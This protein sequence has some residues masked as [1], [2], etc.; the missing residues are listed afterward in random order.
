MPLKGLAQRETKQYG[1]MK[2][3]ELLLAFQPHLPQP[4]IPK[5]ESIVPLNGPGLC[6]LHPGE[7]CSG[8]IRFGDKEGGLE[9]IRLM[10]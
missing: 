1:V 9:S 7:N 6:V 8:R 10:H 2:K 4:Q 5:K 3:N